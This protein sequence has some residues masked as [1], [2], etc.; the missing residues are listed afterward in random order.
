MSTVQEVADRIPERT[1]T[2]LDEVL[3]WRSTLFS[4]I[5]PDAIR[6]HLAR[7]IIERYRQ[8]GL[9]V[10]GWQSSR[11]TPVLLD[12]V[13]EEHL[14]SSADAYRY[15]ALD[16]KYALGPSIA[17]RPAPPQ[18]DNG[19][20]FYW[21]RHIKTIKG[22]SAPA[23]AEPGCIRPDLGA[24]NTVLSLVHASDS[25]E[26]AARESS[27]LLDGKAG[28]WQPPSSLGG[29]LDVSE[30]YWRKESRG[31]P[32]V[33]SELRAGIVSHLWLSLSSEGQLLASQLIRAGQLAAPE[34]GERIRM[35][36]VDYRA[37][38]A[39]PE[40]LAARF[41]PSTAPL[42]IGTVER[43]L[44]GAGLALDD[45]SRTVLDTSMFFEPRRLPLPEK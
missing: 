33:L 1:G 41:D 8:E 39:L 12:G 19:E 40:I 9:A 45:W 7:L 27:I 42:D 37:G 2:H 20:I 23:D 6:R 34:A 26:H 5:G 43:V 21:D 16:A 4:V 38:H 44:V 3:P 28:S 32:E 29:F 30:A 13:Y 14:V 18:G 25:P 22:S 36:L 24:I 15:R 11:I 17:L 10:I 35:H 31:F